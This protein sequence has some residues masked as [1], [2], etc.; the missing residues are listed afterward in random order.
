ML[1]FLYNVRTVDVQLKRTVKITAAIGFF[2][3][4]GVLINPSPFSWG[5]LIGTV[6]SI[7]NSYLIYNRMKHIA[8]MPTN[9]AIAFMRQGFIMRLLLIM[10]VLSFSII[11]D[12]LDIYGVAFGIFIAPIVTVFDFN[13]SVIKDYRTYSAMKNK[14]VKGGKL[15]EES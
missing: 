15:D 13:I 9:K 14:Y 6:V 12:V 5:L 11:T 10:A 3:A 7:I 8:D 4:I 1:D 2:I